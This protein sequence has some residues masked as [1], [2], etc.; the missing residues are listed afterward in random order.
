MLGCVTFGLFLFL[1]LGRPPAAQAGLI[2]GPVHVQP[3][4][5]QSGLDRIWD[6]E[7]HDGVLYVAGEKDSKPAY[8]TINLATGVPGQV[9]VL[10]GLNSSDPTGNIRDVA[11]VNGAVTFVGAAAVAGANHQGVTWDL[12]GTPTVVPSVPDGDGLQAATPS[13]IVVGNG[14]GDEPAV[15]VI[16]GSMVVLPNNGFGLAQS[17][18]DDGKWIVGGDA[19]GYGIWYSDSPES[20]DYVS[21][22][23]ILQPNANGDT[24][25]DLRSVILDPISGHP[26]AI[27]EYTDSVIVGTATAAWDLS[28][29]SLLR[30]FG[31]GTFADARIYGDNLVFAINGPNGGYLG[32]FSGDTIPISSLLGPDAEFIAK[33]GLFEGSLGVFALN[34]DGTSASVGSFEVNGVSAVPE[35]SSWLMM[36]MA[37]IMSF[38]AQ[39]FGWLR[40]LLPRRL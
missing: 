30:D 23:L 34:A 10:S 7:S 38:F 4:T 37:M 27:G 15:G 21:Q 14:N 29:G 12:S 22:N 39:R 3:R 18:T 16:G 26:V 33:G 11:I 20:L 28:D 24:P 35:P 25:Y 36:L 17:I 31:L 40:H 32:T 6:T 5:V 2:L 9:H 1:F 8:Q 13:G 19:F